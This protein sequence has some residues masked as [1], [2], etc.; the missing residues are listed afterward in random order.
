M[1]AAARPRVAA[2]DGELGD[3]LVMGLPLDP[4]G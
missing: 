2:A 3:A 1:T 4:A